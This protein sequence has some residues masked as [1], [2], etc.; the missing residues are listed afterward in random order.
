M[1]FY[2]QLLIFT[3]S[4]AH[5]NTKSGGWQCKNAKNHSMDHKN[6]WTSPKNHLKLSKMRHLWFFRR[7]FSDF[8]QISNLSTSSGMVTVCRRFGDGF[9][10]WGDGPQSWLDDG[11]SFRESS[12]KTN[13]TFT[14]EITCNIKIKNSNTINF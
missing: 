6:A 12:S 8:L 1:H 2:W 4:Y 9:G 11:V 5:Y 3:L 14:T 10:R 7:I 13:L